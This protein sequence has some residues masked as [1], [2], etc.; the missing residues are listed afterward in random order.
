MTAEKKYKFTFGPI[1][2]ATDIRRIEAQYNP[3]KEWKIDPTGYFLIRIHNDHKNNNRKKIEVG[4]CKKLNVVS[5]II[6]GE[7]AEEIYNTIIRE[8]LISKMEHAAYLGSELQKA[9]I[10]L[11][12]GKKYVQDEKLE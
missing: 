5:V 6:E 1:Q 7:N 11:R 10:A 12:L 3:E 4:L 2:E 9:E 8:K